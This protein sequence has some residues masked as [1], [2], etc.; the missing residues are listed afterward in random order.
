MGCINNKSIRN[1]QC[2]IKS[3]EIVDNE[4]R[5]RSSHIISENIST[6][7]LYED[8]HLT[9]ISPNIESMIENNP[10]PFVKIKVKK[11]HL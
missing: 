9:Y 4:K 1:Q 6:K 2:I 10:L 11:N 5:K 8:N 3:K 7:K